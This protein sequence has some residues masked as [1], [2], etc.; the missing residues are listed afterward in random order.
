MHTGN[1]ALLSQAFR[2]L[3]GIGYSGFSQALAHLLRP[4]IPRYAH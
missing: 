4:L 3:V 2:A 1:D